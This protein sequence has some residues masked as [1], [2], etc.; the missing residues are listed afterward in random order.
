M[1][2][3]DQVHTPAFYTAQ[4]E[5]NKATEFANELFRIPT[6]SITELEPFD[7]A[8]DARLAA[9]TQAQ[10][11]ER[12]SQRQVQLPRMDLLTPAL[13]TERGSCKSSAFFASARPG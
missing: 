4:D 8:T 11:M 6:D 10:R 9:L 5:S 12:G 7:E 13:T 1:Q 3:P 2:I